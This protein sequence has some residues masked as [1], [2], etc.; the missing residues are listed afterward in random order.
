LTS[1]GAELI[2]PPTVTPWNSLNARLQGPAD[3]QLTIFTE[4]GTTVNPPARS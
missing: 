1:A 4:L 2:A 3:V